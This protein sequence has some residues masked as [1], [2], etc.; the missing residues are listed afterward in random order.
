MQSIGK[1]ASHEYGLTNSYHDVAHEK[2]G[3]LLINTGLLKNYT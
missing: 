1:R 2:Q 3:N